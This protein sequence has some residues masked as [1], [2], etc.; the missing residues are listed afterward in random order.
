MARVLFEFTL[1]RPVCLCNQ[2]A[3]IEA[4]SGGNPQHGV[5]GWITHLALDI[6]DHLVG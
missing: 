6:A 5:Q 4:Q 2:F 1:R 3:Q